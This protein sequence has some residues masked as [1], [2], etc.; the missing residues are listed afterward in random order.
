MK[1]ATLVE[2]IIENKDYK[3]L[4]FELVGEEVEGKI[5]IRKKYG[6][7]FIV[8]TFVKDKETNTYRH[9]EN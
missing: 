6:R 8:L 5:T 2:K 9:V 4:G 3:D 7:G 1:L